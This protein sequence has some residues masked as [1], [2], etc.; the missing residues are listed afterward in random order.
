MEGV[1]NLTTIPSRVFGGGLVVLP[2]E[3]F[4]SFR[5]D[6]KV[7]I[8]LFG[9]L[10]ECLKDCYCV[11]LVEIGIWSDNQREVTGA[12]RVRISQN[13]E[14]CIRDLNASSNMPIR[15]VVRINTPV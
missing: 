10:D 11:V 8:C 12:R 2:C 13:N 5:V 9:P 3:G 15:L 6:Y 14:R 7:R 4:N 1:A